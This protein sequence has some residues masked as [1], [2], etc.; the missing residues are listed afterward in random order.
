MEATVIIS[1]KE[2]DELRESKRV[3]EETL[4]HFVNMAHGVKGIIS[5]NKGY[6]PF[7]ESLRVEDRIDKALEVYYG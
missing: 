1:L 7:T 2:L 6:L 4:D 5:N 3:T